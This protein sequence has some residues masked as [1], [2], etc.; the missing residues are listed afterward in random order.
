MK[1]TPK[2]LREILERHEKFLLG[3]IGGVQV[4]LIGVNLSEANLSGAVAC[5][6]S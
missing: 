2:Q 4:N 1:Y 6:Q 5:K 3:V